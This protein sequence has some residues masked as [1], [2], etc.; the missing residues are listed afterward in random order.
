MESGEG[1][2]G[3]DAEHHQ[4]GGG[5]GDR[6]GWHGDG[7]CSYRGYGLSRRRLGILAGRVV[8]IGARR[9]ARA[10]AA[11][12]RLSDSRQAL[13][14]GRGNG[15][16]RRRG[17]SRRSRYH[18]RDQH[19]D[20]HPCRQH[21]R[22]SQRHTGLFG[23]ARTRSGLPGPGGLTEPRG[24]PARRSTPKPPAPGKSESGLPAG[25]SRESISRFLREGARAWLQDPNI[26][27]ISV[28]EKESGGEGT[29]ITAVRFEVVGKLADRADIIRAGT[30]PI[31]ERIEIDG[32]SLPT[33]VEEGWPEAHALAPS[34]AK[35]RHD[36]VSGGIS[37]GTRTDT[38]TLGALLWHKPSGQP[39]A[40]SNWHILAN[41]GE[42]APTFQPGPGD[43][44]GQSHPLGTLRDQVLD[45]DLDAAISTVRGRGVRVEIAGLGVPVSAVAA[46]KLDMPVVKAGKETGI[47]FGRI[48]NVEMQLTYRVFGLPE[49]HAIMVCVI[50]PD[51]QRPASSALS[52]HGDSGSCWML[53]GDDGRP[54]GTM[55]GLHVAGDAGKK[56]A[57]ACYADKVFER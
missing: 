29:G 14:S 11:G 2:R 5:A 54:T 26:V 3:R 40:L 28:G 56:L 12:S 27:G 23:A 39:V 46:P 16:G 13:L 34:N 20:A 43:S 9:F 31:P 22:P 24:M 33:D 1:G 32:I 48:S 10:S 47:T 49:R 41:D 51:P 53:V 52:A 38:G 45:I 30:R 55:I 4:D 21:E 18:E 57:Y 8:N 19:E 15:I 36:P 42:G 25:L 6:P 50:K 44:A 17:D 7:R 35:A 37:I